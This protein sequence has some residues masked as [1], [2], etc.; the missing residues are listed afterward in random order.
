VYIN[1]VEKICPLIVFMFKLGKRLKLCCAVLYSENECILFCAYYMYQ[2]NWIFFQF[3]SDLL[4]IDN[5]TCRICPYTDI[6][7]CLHMNTCTLRG[8]NIFCV[9]LD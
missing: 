6:Q 9:V 1:H 4:C 2:C 8:L 7:T 5:F 3:S